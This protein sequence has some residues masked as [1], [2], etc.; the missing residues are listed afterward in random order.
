MTCNHTR[1][2]FGCKSCL[3]KRGKVYESEKHYQLDKLRDLDKIIERLHEVNDCD[4]MD[5]GIIHALN[6]IEELTE[7]INNE[8]KRQRSC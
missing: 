5:P 7:S 2:H 8:V 3:I 6:I 4:G 1:L